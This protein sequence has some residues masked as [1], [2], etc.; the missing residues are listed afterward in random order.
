MSNLYSAS[1]QKAPLHALNVP[2]TYQKDTFSV[3][4]ENSQFACP[5][6]ANCFGTNRSFVVSVCA[7]H[8][9]TGEYKLKLTYL[10]NKPKF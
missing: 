7:C 1:S 9:E 4:N 5:A 6:H 3:Y 2:S 10:L 8:V